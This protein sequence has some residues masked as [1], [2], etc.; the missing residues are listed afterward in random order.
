MMSSKDF[1]ILDASLTL[2]HLS[3]DEKEAIKTLIALS[4]LEANDMHDMQEEIEIPAERLK[5]LE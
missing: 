3:K 4:I 5:I 1:D 2:R